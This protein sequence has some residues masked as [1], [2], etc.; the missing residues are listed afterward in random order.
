MLTEQQIKDLYKPIDDMPIGNQRRHVKTGNK[1]R[2][3][4][5]KRVI[6]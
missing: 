5:K 1:Y 6:K 2:G 3:G 4:S